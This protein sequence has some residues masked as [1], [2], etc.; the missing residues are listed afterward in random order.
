MREKVR[1]Y[2]RTRKREARSL[3]SCETK[4]DEST[5]KASAKQLLT[6]SLKS[7]KNLSVKS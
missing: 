4:L 1:E 2:D 3:Q 5:Y 7:P 6:L